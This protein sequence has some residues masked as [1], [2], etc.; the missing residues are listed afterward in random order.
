MRILYLITRAEPGGAQV[1]L[2]HLF[3]AF[4][5]RAELHLA[6]GEDKDHFLLDEAWALGVKVHTL[7]HL[8][9]PIS[10]LKDVAA[11]GEVLTLLR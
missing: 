3:K 6:V 2:L 10:P 1:H 4:R 11:V 5:P 7:R 9:W 8:V